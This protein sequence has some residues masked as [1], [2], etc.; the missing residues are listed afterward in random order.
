MLNLEDFKELVADALDGLPEE[1]HLLMDRNNVVVV[2]ERWPSPEQI[3][4]NGLESRYQL[5]G[6]YEGI[7]LT[8]RAGYNL[9]LP[10]K[11]T[12]FQG[13]LESTCAT[14]EELAAEVQ[15]T[16]AHEIAHHFGMDHERL[17]EL[18]LG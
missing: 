8:Q 11:I 3:A 13:P 4:E 5:L 2:V 15:V 9:V 18:G 10:D 14:R 1:L 7:P 16:V 6:L 12:I 17:E